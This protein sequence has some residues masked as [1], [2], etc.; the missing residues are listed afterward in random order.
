MNDVLDYKGW[1]LRRFWRP[2]PVQINAATFT[3]GGELD[4]ERFR[5]D[6]EEVIE[7]IW[8]GRWPGRSTYGPFPRGAQLNDALYKCREKWGKPPSY[9]AVLPKPGSTWADVPII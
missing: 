1:R 7:A 9:F 6:T 5:I 2:R 3:E 8:L 4:P